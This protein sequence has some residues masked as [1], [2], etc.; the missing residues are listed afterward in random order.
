MRSELKHSCG[1]ALAAAWP[2]RPRGPADRR[3]GRG[4]AL[5]FV[6][7]LC[8]A[9][10]ARSD[11]F[12]YTVAPGDNPW[13][14]SERLL[15]D[16]S[17]WP[18]LQRHNH[19]VDDR[20]L[21]PGSVL[22]IPEAWLR[23]RG[24]SLQV[25]ALAGPVQIKRSGAWQAA[26]R[27]DPL[28]AGDRLQT[29]AHGSATLALDQTATVL[30]RQSTEIRLVEASRETTREGGGAPRV[31]IELLQG[32][33]ENAV[34]D[35]R[36]SGGELQIQT[37]TA[38]TTVRGT[39]FRVSADAQTTRTEVLDGLVGFDN[40]HGQT[41]I[42]A[43]RGSVAGRGAAPLLPVELPPA[44]D[45]GRVEQRQQAWPLQG[46]IGGAGRYRLQLL[47]GT[48]TSVL[49]EAAGAD[50]SSLAG[51]WPDGSY[52]LRVRAIAANGLEGLSAE[53]TLEVDAQPAPPKLA[54][55]GPSAGSTAPQ[56]H[57]SAPQPGWRWRLQISAATAGTDAF[58]Q[59]AVLRDQWL[60]QPRHTPAGLPVGP[61]A[62]RV[63][64]VD[65]S[66]QGPWSRVA[67]FT[68]RQW[69]PR[70]TRLTLDDDVHLGWQLDAPEDAPVRVQIALDPAFRQVVFDEIQHGRETRLPR[71][72]HGRYHLRM[73]ALEHSDEASQW[74]EVRPLTVG[75]SLFGLR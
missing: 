75:W 16:M 50:L 55:D 24:T 52:R 69:V 72:D 13:S 36:K 8:A 4:R 40:P 29:G 63:A 27:G 28:R 48:G 58:A 21:P 18:R 64:S 56:L 5:L 67:R 70:W 45:L 14:I 42:P 19:I 43:G 23:L 61:Y 2:Q 31:R 26:Q 34:H 10:I 1:R 35:L 59:D 73:S 7:L 12:L 39:E 65:G 71:P 20:R 25:T 3:L 53:R 49:A 41:D 33:L 11:D 74:S 6:G 44:P 22:R 37:P 30:L 57:W 60:D 9:G 51:E 68:V 38:I 54:T 32:G 17:Y 46:E 66:D 47:A 15:I 62:W